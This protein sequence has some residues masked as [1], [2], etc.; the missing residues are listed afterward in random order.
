MARSRRSA[1]LPPSEA[2]PATTAPVRRAAAA[3]AWSHPRT[4]TTSV[5]TTRRSVSPSPSTARPWRDSGAGRSCGVH[6]LV[7]SVNEKSEEAHRCYNTSLLLGPDGSL[8]GRTAR[9]TCSTWMYPRTSAS[10]SPTPSSPGTRPS[11]SRPRW[12][13]SAC[14]F[15]DLRFPEMYR[16]LVDAGAE[17]LAIPAAFTLT[18]AATTGTLDARTR[19]RDPDRHR[20][21]PRRQARRR[22]PASLFGHSMI[23]KY[24]PH[25][26]RRAQPGPG[27]DRPLS[28]RSRASRH[29]GARP[30][31]HR[32]TP[33]GPAAPP[34]PRCH[35]SC[36]LARPR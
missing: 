7:G 28:C 18:T 3:S 12:A 33:S 36:A 32:L 10:R 29:A 15:Y 22:R 34:A 1:L 21:W 19:H 31:P 14:R 20:P 13:P 5:P 25:V 9:C 27:R 26:R 35:A 4:P 24:I 30:P 2:N 8:L 6:L 17:I 11:S 23:V 16:A